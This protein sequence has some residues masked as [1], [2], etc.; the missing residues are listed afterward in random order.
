[1]AKHRG[2]RWTLHDLKEWVLLT[3]GLGGFGH[4]ELSKREPRPYLL[5]GYL[6][7]MGLSAGLEDLLDLLGITFTR[8]RE[9]PPPEE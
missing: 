9:E 6:A 4:E 7:M 1:V 3:C 5:L 2:G 8:R